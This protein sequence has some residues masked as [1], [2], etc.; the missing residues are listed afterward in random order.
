MPFA[1]AMYMQ[2]ASSDK[3]LVVDSIPC[4]SEADISSVTRDVRELARKALQRTN[5]QVGRSS[6]PV[7]AILVSIILPTLLCEL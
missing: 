2:K 6:E 1:S 4:D 5:S 3:W 7:S